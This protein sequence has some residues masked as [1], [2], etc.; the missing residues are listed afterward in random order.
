VKKEYLI[1]Y[2]YGMGGVW[3]ILAARSEQEICEKYPELKVF[4]VRPSWMS[5][6]YYN[7]IRD[8]SFDIDVVPTGWLATLRK[9]D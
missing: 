6:A 1:V 3:A 5:D 7:N 8:N 4:D 9:G 2:D